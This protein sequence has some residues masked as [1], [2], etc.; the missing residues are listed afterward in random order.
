MV[1]LQLPAFFEELHQQRLG[2]GLVYATINFRR[3]VTRGVVEQARA[4]FDSP[5][6]GIRGAELNTADAGKGDGR[7]AHAAGLKCYI[8]IAIDQA[9]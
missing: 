1:N 4:V 8:E 6:L 3:V 9:G 2:S 5:H 7:G